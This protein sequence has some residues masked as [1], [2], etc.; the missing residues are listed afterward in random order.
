MKLIFIISGFIVLYV[1][2]PRLFAYL[3]KRIEERN[4]LLDKKPGKLPKNVIKFGEIFEG[5]H[6]GC[7]LDAPHRHGS[8]GQIFHL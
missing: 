7:A 8:K 2:L 5:A 6:E 3:R 1:G 4:K